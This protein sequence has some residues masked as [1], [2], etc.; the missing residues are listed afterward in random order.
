M[1]KLPLI[2][3]HFALA[4]VPAFSQAADLAVTQ[5]Y[6]DKPIRL[7]VPFGAGASTDTVARLVAQ[8]L[9]EAL[10]E[11]VIVENRPGGNG[12]I[13]ARTVLNAPADGY[14]ILASGSALQVFNP[15]TFADITYKPD[16]L[17][18]ITVLAQYPLVIAVNNNTPIRTLA[19]FTKVSHDKPDK[20]TY[21]FTGPTFQAQAEYLFS[22][23][24]VKLLPVPYNGGGAALL[25][26]MAGDTDVIAQDPTSIA[27]MHK[28]GKLRAIAVTSSNR[29]SALPD[30]PTVAESGLPG[31]ETSVFTGLA[32]RRGTPPEIVQ[33]LN[34]E[35]SKVLALPEVRNRIES[36]GMTAIGSTPEAS[37][38]KIRHEIKLYTPIVESSGMRVKQ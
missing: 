10:K 33:K 3:V 35:I 28:S 2:V 26:V 20:F 13:G 23:L 6:P 27:P 38:E 1:R 37:A 7:I 31:F 34:A 15:L 25:S 4:L 19:D 21:G 29:N 18:P 9:G 22:K 17:I 16:D 32:V 36:L 24:K 5:L 12:T 8:H 30:V 11:S 14:T